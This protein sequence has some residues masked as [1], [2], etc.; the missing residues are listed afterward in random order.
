MALPGRL[1]ASLALVSVPL[2]LTHRRALKPREGL[3]ARSKLMNGLTGCVPAAG[4]LT[5]EAGKSFG[6]CLFRPWEP[7]GTV[8]SVGPC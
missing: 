1:D 6:G 5:A 8:Q 3:S 7:A 4:P 2:V